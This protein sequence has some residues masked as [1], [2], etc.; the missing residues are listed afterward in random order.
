M[1]QAYT[2]QFTEVFQ[3][4]GGLVPDSYAIG[5]HPTGWDS[6][7]N[8]QRGFFHLKVGEMQGGS[9]VDV[10]IWQ[11]TDAAGAGA[12]IVAGKAITQL[13]AAGGDGGDDVCIE[14]RTEEM[15]V[16]DDYCYINAYVTVG[17]AASELAATM[18]L[19]ASNYPP[20]PVTA[21]TEIID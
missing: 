12:Q 13:T 3:L 7:A 18:F 8:H 19:G 17:G 15:D 10:Q 9:T 4:G 21:W 14:I 20:V 6:M 16:A 11:A 2:Y 1:T 5:I